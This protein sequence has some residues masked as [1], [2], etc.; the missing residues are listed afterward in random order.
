MLNKYRGNLGV[1]ALPQELATAANRTVDNLETQTARLNIDR[2]EMAGGRLRAD[3]RV[4]NT[5]GHKFPTGY[6][7]RRTWLHVTVRD[8]ANRVVFESGGLNPDGSITGNDNDANALQYEPH[9]RE[10]AAGDQVQIYESIMVDSA[11]APTTGLLNA[12]RFVKDNRL[13]PKGFAKQTADA[14]IAPQGD[15]MADP[16]FTGDGDRIRYSINT[17]SAT[18]PFKVEAELMYQ[19]VSYRWANNLAKYDAPEPKRFVGYYREM[20]NVSAVTVAR[21]ER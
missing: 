6:P 12:I 17:G 4:E 15:A 8:A 16:D 3:I 21:A 7:S 20:A 2:V 10:I 18:G 13:L 19:V 9:Y 5:A 11:G 14:E 1:W